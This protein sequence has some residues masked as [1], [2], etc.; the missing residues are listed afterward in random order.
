MT[1]EQIMELTIDSIIRT[2]PR[3]LPDMI[4]PDKCL[5]Q[6]GANSI[7]RVDI[8]TMTADRLGIRIPMVELAGAKNIEALIELFHDRVNNT[9]C[10]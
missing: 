1:K 5:K 4:T 7:D 10:I 8:M 2:L 6:L 3:L 9:S